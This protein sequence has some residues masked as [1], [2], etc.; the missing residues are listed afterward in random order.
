MDRKA[1]STVTLL[2]IAALF[3]QRGSTPAASA[4]EKASPKLAPVLESTG[5][6]PWKPICGHFRTTAGAESLRECLA[7]PEAKGTTFRT[8]IATVPDPEQTHLALYFD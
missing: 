2:F 1:V 6:G 7:L 3:S 4:P 5:S 8:I